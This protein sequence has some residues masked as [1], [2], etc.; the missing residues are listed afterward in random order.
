MKSIWVYLPVLA[1]LASC[2]GNPTANSGA[3][4]ANKRFA[5]QLF[6]MRVKARG[7]EGGGSV[8][9]YY[10]AGTMGQS[11][12]TPVVEEDIYKMININCHY[13]PSDLK[14]VNVVRHQY[15][16]FYEVWVFNDK[17]SRR[18]DKTSALSVILKALPNNG[19]T[20]INTIGSCHA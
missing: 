13:S 10:W 14:Q 17:E 11:V 4:I 8:M 12:A 15:P 6:P 3:E 9:M 1:F 19:G 2:A 20:D 18:E 16:M 5:E 7:V